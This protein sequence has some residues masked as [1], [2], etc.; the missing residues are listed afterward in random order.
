MDMS[1][2]PLRPYTTSL[3]PCPT[4]MTTLAMKKSAPRVK[5]VFEHT[6]KMS[7]RSSNSQSRD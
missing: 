3:P 1:V 2:R 6:L 7:P 4:F 5:C